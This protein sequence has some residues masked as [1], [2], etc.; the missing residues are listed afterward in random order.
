M[1][2]G[3]LPV[4]AED[5]T[6]RVARFALAMQPLVN[7]IADKFGMSGLAMR[8]GLHTGEVVA[9]VIGKKKFAYDLWGDTVNIASRMES[10]GEAGKVHVSEEVF[11]L[12]KDT[13]AFEK[14]GEIDIKGKGVMQT[15]FL[16]NR[17]TPHSKSV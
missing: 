5:H 11:A 12:L 1:V 3:G 7:E 15:Y 9:G 13:F 8:I 4:L 2:V 6:E 10:H 14:R 16:A 17:R